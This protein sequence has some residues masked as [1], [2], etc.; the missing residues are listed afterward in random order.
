MRVI[1]TLEQASR[2]QL[3]RMADEAI[4]ARRD[5]TARSSVLGQLLESVARLEVEVRQLRS[6]QEKSVSSTWLTRALEPVS[7]IRKRTRKTVAAV[8]P[9]RVK[10]YIR[11]HQ[12]KRRAQ[13]LSSTGLFDPAYYLT[14][15][16]DVG[17]AG[18]PP[19]DHYLIFGPSEGRDPHEMF[20]T[21]YYLEHNPDVANSGAHPLLHFYFHGLAEGRQ[22][23]P[24]FSAAQYRQAT[25]HIASDATRAEPIAMCFARPAPSAGC[26]AI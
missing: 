19:M 11:K 13:L 6:A 16:P 7:R 18:I 24:G 23:H 2:A 25:A 10:G 14:Q 3:E 12:L 15:N 20:D 4:S 21:S 22:P 26:A 17:A 1:S 5:F 9:K 8:V